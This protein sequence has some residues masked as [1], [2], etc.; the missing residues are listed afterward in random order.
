[1]AINTNRQGAAFELAVAKDL[2]ERGWW[3]TRVS[4]S[5]GGCDVVAICADEVLLVE[6]KLHGLLPPA[7]WNEIYDLAMSCGAVPVLAYREH[8]KRAIHYRRLIGRKDGTRRR[9]PFDAFNPGEI[10][11]GSRAAR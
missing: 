2:L 3:A 4:A 8:R 9:Q 10:P 11:T 1:M 6:C 7:Q 5:K